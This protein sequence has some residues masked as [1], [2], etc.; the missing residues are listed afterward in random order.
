M[1]AV[2]VEIARPP[3]DVWRAFTDVSLLAAWMPGVRRTQIVDQ[4]PGERPREILF[5]FSTSLTYTLVYTYDEDKREVHWEP[6]V[7]RRDAV[8]GFARVEASGAGSRL[9]YSLEQGSGRTTEDLIL[10]GPQAVV[11]AFVRWI[12]ARR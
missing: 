4:P 9:T 12:E 5:E 6:R 1:P 7:G 11:E 2:V 10:G 8:R 3:A